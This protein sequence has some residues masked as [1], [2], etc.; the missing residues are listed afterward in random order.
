M[1]RSNTY[2]D[3]KM[4]NGKREKNFHSI[5][6]LGTKDKEIQFEGIEKAEEEVGETDRSSSNGR[7]FLR[8]FISF[9]CFLLNY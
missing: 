5:S 3:K 8:V 2:R 1:S 7:M 9:F 6:D 4:K